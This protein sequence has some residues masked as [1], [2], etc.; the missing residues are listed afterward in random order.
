VTKIGEVGG[1]IIPTGMRSV[2]V[3]LFVKFHITV[4]NKRF[5]WRP[6]RDLVL[7]LLSSESRSLRDI[8]LIS[9]FLTA[10][11]VTDLLVCFAFRKK[12]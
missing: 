4:S 10:A 9:W 5:P 2:V 6:L 1:V 8:P 12:R 11:P 7:P 3:N